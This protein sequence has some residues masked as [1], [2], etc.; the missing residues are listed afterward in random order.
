MMLMDYKIFI[1]E[2]REYPLFF[3]SSERSLTVV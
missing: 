3:V 2:C 1:F